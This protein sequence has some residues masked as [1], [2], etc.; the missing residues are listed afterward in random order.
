MYTVR[1]SLAKSEKVF[2]CCNQSDSFNGTDLFWAL[3]VRLRSF[4]QSDSDTFCFNL[5]FLK[6]LAMIFKFS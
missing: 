6:F 1:V 2:L 3:R 5:L 4:I